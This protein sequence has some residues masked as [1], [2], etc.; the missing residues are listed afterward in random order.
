MRLRDTVPYVIWLIV[1]TFLPPRMSEMEDDDE[2]EEEDDLDETLDMETEED[3]VDRPD[4][5]TTLDVDAK[6]P[7]KV[8][9]PFISGSIAAC[10][11]V[12]SVDAGNWA[13]SAFPE[14]SLKICIQVFKVM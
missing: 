5:G 11:I 3:T 9:K 7:T 6:N 1:L 4:N 13:N 10:I 8:R 12:Q 2:E 14:Q